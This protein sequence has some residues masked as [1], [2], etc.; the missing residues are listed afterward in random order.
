MVQNLTAES[1]DT[2]FKVLQHSHEV[3]QPLFLIFE[4]VT[5]VPK[6]QAENT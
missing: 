2:S 3:L 1:N 4:P 5:P 6:H